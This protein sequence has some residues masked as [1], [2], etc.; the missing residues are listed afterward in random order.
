MVEQQHKS[1][2]FE[3]NN[4]IIQN[5]DKLSMLS[6]KF[7]VSTETDVNI[8]NKIIK[9]FLFICLQQRCE[10]NSPFKMLCF[11]SVFHGK[12]PFNFTAV[13]ANLNLFEVIKCKLSGIF[14]SLTSFSLSYHKSL[15]S[16]E[17]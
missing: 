2:T 1:K 10:T 5:R 12:F 9:S 13:K 7:Q 16:P 3:G 11:V 15:K 8:R 14:P 17:L 6:S 4:E